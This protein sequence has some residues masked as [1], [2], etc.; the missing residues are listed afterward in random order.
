VLVAT[1][2]AGRGLDIP[3]VAHVINYDLPTRSIENY[4][5]RI[6]RTGRAGKEGVA[7]S[8]IT[9]E[10]EGIMAPLKAYLEST[11]NRVPERLARHPAANGN[12]QNNLIY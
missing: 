7:T 9:D 5:H 11:G 1:D 3:D 8:F 12:V 2:V 10:D 4:T 6:G